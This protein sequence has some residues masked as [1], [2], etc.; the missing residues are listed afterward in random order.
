MNNSNPNNKD[1]YDRTTENAKAIAVLRSEVRD[2]KEDIS[3]LKTNDLHE[4]NK[5]V[6]RLNWWLVLLLG[7]LAV[8]LAVLLLEK[9]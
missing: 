6:D 2:I 1:L 7:G 5:K 4:L 3:N 8:N 9:L